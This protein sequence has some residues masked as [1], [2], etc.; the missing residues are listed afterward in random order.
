MGADILVVV[1]LPSAIHFTPT[2]QSAVRYMDTKIEATE[3]IFY[4]Q[5]Y[6]FDELIYIKTF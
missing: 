5:K 2:L 3:L 6:I 1:A 4:F